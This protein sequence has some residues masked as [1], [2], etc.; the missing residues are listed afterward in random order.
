MAIMASLVLLWNSEK[1]RAAVGRREIQ[2]FLIG[3][4]LVSICEIISVGGFP[5][6]NNV[7]IAFSAVHIALI[8]STSWILLLN[9]IVGYQVID[10]GTF[11]SVGAMVGSSLLFFIATGYV[12]LDTGYNWTG[13]FAYS[14]DYKNIALYVLYQLLPLIFIVGFFLLETNIVLRVLK[15]KKPMIFLASAALLFA[16]GQIFQYIV[17]THICNGT[18][19]KINGA[20][21]ETL[22]TLLSVI[23]LWTFWSSITEDDWPMAV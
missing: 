7:R 16:I 2:I 17:S 4:I 12:A 14:S 11:V 23:T 22:F 10:D 3:Y 15:E 21:L 13:R 20:F 1:K 8:V 19:G 5:L 6:S 9:G 18:D